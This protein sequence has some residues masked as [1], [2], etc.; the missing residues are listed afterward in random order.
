MMIN[1]IAKVRFH[2]V[3]IIHDNAADCKKFRNQIGRKS[4]NSPPVGDANPILSTGRR[5]L[6]QCLRDKFRVSP[7]KKGGLCKQAAS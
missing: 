5:G 1:E 7:T 4:Q 3:C 2:I 6:K